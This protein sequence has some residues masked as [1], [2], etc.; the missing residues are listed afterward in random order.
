MV[1]QFGMTA[2]MKAAENGHASIVAYMVLK[3]KAK[4]EVVSNVSTGT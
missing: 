3:G 2:L 1:V 4:L